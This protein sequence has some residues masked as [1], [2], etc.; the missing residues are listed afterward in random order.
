LDP[1][2]RTDIQG[3]RGLSVLLVVFYHTNLLFKGGFIGV[4]VFF[5]ISGYVIM[6]SLLTEYQNHSSISLTKFVSR[7]INRLLP[8]STVVVVITLILSV[9]VFSPFSEQQQVARTSISSTFFSANLYFVLQNSYSALINNPFR[10]MWSLGVEEQFYIF[11]ILSITLIFRFSRKK[12]SIPHKI[13]GFTIATSV[14]SFLANLI[15]SAG[16]RILPLPTRIAFFS[17]LTRIW[18]LQI[19]VIAAFVSTRYLQKFKQT[20]AAEFFTICGIALILYGAFTFNSLTEFPG[21]FA[22]VPTLGGLT[23]VLFANQTRLVARLLS[24]KPLR[25]LGDISYSWYLWHWPIIVFCQILAP[26]NNILLVLS[27]F[28]SVIP[29][30]ISYHLIENRF[31]HQSLT[32]PIKTLSIS[33]ISQVLVACLV[34]IGASTTYGLIDRN[35]T[36]ATDSW[37]SLAGCD[38]KTPEFSYTHCFLNSDKSNKSVLLIGDS[39]AGAISDGVKIATENLGFRFAVWYL[40]ACPFFSRPTIGVDNCEEFHLAIE[41]LV[42][43]MKPDVIIVASKS[44][45][46]TTSGPQGGGY[47]LPEG[48]GSIPKTYS[49]SIE[50]WINGLKEELTKPA[51]SRSEILL[52]QQVPPAPKV[53]PTL[54]NDTPRNS[55]FDLNTVVDRNELAARETELLS[56]VSNLSILDSSLTLCPSK[57]CI[58]TIGNQSLYRDSFHLSPFGARFLAKKIEE[59]LLALT[60]D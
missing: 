39:Q 49:A 35:Q 59:S 23:V 30:S 21:L 38:M 25:Y 44:S 45:L 20:L 37:A 19:G 29:A 17:P 41:Q 1:K 33:I 14:M 34:I 51:F 27:G 5:V 57:S 53:S 52:F 42:A 48:D 22:L 43:Q 28:L 12:N 11:L 58:Q 26:G 13:L 40:P 3:L 36:G 4:D 60:G 47:I 55:R 24:A 7:R 2:Y 16:F 8:A 18:E 56:E 54:L 46:Y 50:N 31:R 32:F 9:F 15:F 10:H 6:S